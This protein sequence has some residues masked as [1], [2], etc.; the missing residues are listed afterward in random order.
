MKKII[1]RTLFLF[2]LLLTVQ[3]VSAAVLT[4]LPGNGATSGNGRAPQGSRNYIN[5]VYY[6]NP[7]EMTASGFGATLVTSVGWT[8]QAG[9]PQNTTTTGTIK[10][11]LQSSA[12]AVYSK[13]STFST[14]GMTKVTDGTITITNSGVQFSIDV[15]TGGTGT[16]SFTTVAGQ[17]LYVAFEYHTTTNFSAM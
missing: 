14:T 11:Y 5:T 12:D 7:S 17:G 8:W 16:S 3:S 15:P 1:Q 13:G 10:T 4:I 2:C 9:T 6:I